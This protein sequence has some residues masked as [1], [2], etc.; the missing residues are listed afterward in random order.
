M[1]TNSNVR[2]VG[3]VVIGARHQH[4]GRNG[5]DAVATFVVDGVAVGVVCDGCSSGASSEVGARLGARWFAERLGHALVAGAD[6]VDR[7]TWEV[8]RRD[9]ATRLR[10]I[11]EVDE[12]AAIDAEAVH[13]LLLFT[14]V[15]VAV[16]P[17]GAAVWALGDG[18]YGCAGSVHVLGPFTDNAPPYLA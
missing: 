3:G 18:A 5:Q 6:V 2:A 10:A 13:E 7:A 15:A 8:A 16:T 9:V 12:L 14:I 4:A 11:A 17:D 1:N